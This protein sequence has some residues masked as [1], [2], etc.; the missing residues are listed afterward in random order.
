MGNVAT[1]N[2]K[3]RHE[4]FHRKDKSGNSISLEFDIGTFRIDSAYM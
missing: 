1:G 3:S 2:T 4:I